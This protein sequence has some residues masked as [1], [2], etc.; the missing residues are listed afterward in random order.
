M[1]TEKK[2]LNKG[3]VTD[4]P[5]LLPDDDSVASHADMVERLDEG[6]SRDYLH[7]MSLRA[8]RN[9][10]VRQRNQNADSHERP[11]VNSESRKVTLNSVSRLAAARLFIACAFPKMSRT[12]ALFSEA[13]AYALMTEHEQAAYEARHRERFV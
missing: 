9:L 6:N 2:Y 11:A 12:S 5:V 13:V 8:L 4:G 10:V 3:S 1:T 7:G